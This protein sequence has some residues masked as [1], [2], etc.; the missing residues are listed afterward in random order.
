MVILYG[1]GEA[2][3]EIGCCQEYAQRLAK[4]EGI[5]QMKGG[6][7]LFTK[8][9]LTRLKAKARQVGHPRK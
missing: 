3:E 5:G 2:A 6:V 4:R 1:T 7:W 9:D 8:G